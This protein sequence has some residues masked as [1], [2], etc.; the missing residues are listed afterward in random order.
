MSDRMKDKIIVITGAAR[1]IG[2]SL[3]EVF[4]REGGKV[5]ILDLFQEAVDNAVYQLKQKGYSADGY[6]VNITDSQVV[7]TVITQ[8][9]TNYERIDVLINNA[10]I[11]KD[12]LI[13]RMKEEEW[14][15]VINVN[16]KGCLLYTSPSPRDQA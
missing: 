1:G 15:A 9:I 3:A 14:D 7:E 5:I 4:G 6:A 16:L 8:I 11:T 10:G 2:Y 13:L 12:N